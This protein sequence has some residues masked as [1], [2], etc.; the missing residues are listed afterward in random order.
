MPE[1]TRYYHLDQLR[2]ADLGQWEGAAGAVDDWLFREH[3]LTSSNHA[4]GHLFGLLADAGYTVTPNA[5][6]LGGE[7]GDP[8]DLVP[9][10]RF[11]LAYREN[12]V[13]KISAKKSALAKRVER[14]TRFVYSELPEDHPEREAWAVVAEY[15]GD[16][17]WDVVHVGTCLDAGVDRDT[18]L[19]LAEAYSHTITVSGLTAADVLARHAAKESDRD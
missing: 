1:S 11:S 6:N 17:Q 16:G 3:G 19:L 4:V 14:A 9:E 7:D 18:A 5:D 8:D 13:R 10:L 12:Q 2:R 15:R